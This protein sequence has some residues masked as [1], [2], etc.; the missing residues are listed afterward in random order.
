[1]PLRKPV[2]P[3]SSAVIKVE[4]CEEAV[5]LSTF[6]IAVGGAIFCRFVGGLSSSSSPT[7]AD[8]FRDSGT[9]ADAGAGT[10]GVDTVVVVVAVTV[11][12]AGAV[13]VGTPSST[14]AGDT[15]EGMLRV[16]TV[17]CCRFWHVDEIQDGLVCRM[18]SD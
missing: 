12:G 14:G 13:D 16:F 2:F 5:W 17:K 1:M 9:D 3:M 11:A 18:H 15:E 4:T 8:R 10:G 7:P 6:R